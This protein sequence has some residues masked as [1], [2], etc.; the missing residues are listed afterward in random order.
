MCSN[1]SNRIENLDKKHCKYLTIET[2]KASVCNVPEDEFEN[3]VDDI[4]SKYKVH[5]KI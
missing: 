1:D 5:Y 3:F 2:R 4:S